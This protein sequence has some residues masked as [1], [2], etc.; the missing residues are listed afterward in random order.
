VM[1][2]KLL[3]ILVIAFTKVLVPRLMQFCSVESFKC[4][5]FESALELAVT[6]YRLAADRKH[7]DGLN[8]PGLCYEFDSRS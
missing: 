4:G 6:C 8:Y 7:G 1:I 3:S 2:R 5:G